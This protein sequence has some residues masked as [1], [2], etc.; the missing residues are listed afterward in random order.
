MVRR[1]CQPDNN[2]RLRQLLQ[3]QQLQQ[4]QHQQ[5]RRIHPAELLNKFLFNIHYTLLQNVS[6]IPPNATVTMESIKIIRRQRCTTRTAYNNINNMI[7]MQSYST[8]NTPALTHSTSSHWLIISLP[9]NQHTITLAETKSSQLLKS[10]ATTLHHHTGYNHHHHI[11]LATITANI[12]ILLQLTPKGLEQQLSNLKS[13]M[14]N[15]QPESQFIILPIGNN[16]P[17]HHT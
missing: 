9:S 14:V 17:N 2:N 10:P 13:I 11:T 1:N 15:W 3:Q 12:Y 5:R 16:Q 6:C 7:I 4:Q 8:T